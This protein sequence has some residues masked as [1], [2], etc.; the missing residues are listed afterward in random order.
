[1]QTVQETQ[2][3]IHCAKSVWSDIS[4][5]IGLLNMPTLVYPKAKFDNIRTEILNKLKEKYDV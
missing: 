2:E 1:M 3:F 5:L 4:S